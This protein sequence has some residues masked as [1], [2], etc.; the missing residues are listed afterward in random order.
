MNQAAQV[1]EAL[2][3]LDAVRAR[4]M[5]GE[6]VAV[7]AIAVQDNGTV[8]TFGRLLRQEAAPVQRE[9]VELR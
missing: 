4:I 1:I 6:I 9:K 5:S 2:S 7:T 8:E 3:M